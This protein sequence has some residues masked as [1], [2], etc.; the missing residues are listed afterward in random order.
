MNKDLVVDPRETWTDVF[1]R[2]R[3]FEDAKMIP[4]E[5]LSEEF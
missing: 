4:R 3:D 1:K 5:E 2:I